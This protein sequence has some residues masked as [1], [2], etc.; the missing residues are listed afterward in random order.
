MR[1]GAAVPTFV[2]AW[3]GLKC[4]RVERGL[5]SYACLVPTYVY[6]YIDE[7][8]HD[9]LHAMLYAIYAILVYKEQMYIA[10]VYSPCMLSL[11]QVHPGTNV[12]S[13]PS[14]S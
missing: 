6:L 7:S 8:S 11:H 5:I 9:F 12:L 10:A 1:T 14:Y 4:G 3:V 13:F 2:L